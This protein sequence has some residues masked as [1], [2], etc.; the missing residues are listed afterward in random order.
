MKPIIIENT[1]VALL[2]R[3]NLLDRELGKYID[4]PDVQLFIKIFGL[5]GDGDRLSLIHLKDNT[6][7]FELDTAKYVGD[8][9]CAIIISQNGSDICTRNVAPLKVYKINQL[10]KIQPSC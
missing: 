4:I 7:T 10:P 2:L 8:Y 1:K 3:I 5:R 9:N 6:Y